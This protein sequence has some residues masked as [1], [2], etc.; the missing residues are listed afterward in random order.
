MKKIFV[1]I[2]F[3]FYPIPNINAAQITEVISSFEKEDPFDLD[4]EIKYHHSSRRGKI[5]RE[6]KGYS[7][8]KERLATVDVSKYSETNHILSIETTFGLYHDLELFFSFP[9]ILE[10]SSKLTP[11]SYVSNPESILEGL[12]DLPFSSPKRAGL[13]FFSTGINWA[14]ITQ[15]KDKTKP[16]W[17]LSIEGR[18]GVGK[19]MKAVKKGD[20]T[21]GGISRG[22][23]EV[24]WATSISKRFKRIEPYTQFFYLLSFPKASSVYSCEYSKSECEFQVYTKPPHQGGMKWGI[25]IYPWENIKAHQ[26]LSIDL[27][28]YTTFYSEGRSYSELFDALG[29][30]E[31]LKTDLKGNKTPFNGLTDTQEYTSFGGNLILNIQPSQYTLFSIGFGI[32]HDQA[33]FITFSDIRRE[34]RKEGGQNPYYRSQIDLPGQRFKVENILLIDFFMVAKGMF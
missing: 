32:G 4:F 31:I 30:S 15:K 6:N 1:F 29:T 18:F 8:R 34:E 21:S 19:P 16:T 12:F 17:V 9:I 26:R 22:L 28:L 13:D 27:R 7:H 10:K 3:F 33:H 25:E 14:P 20:K 2:L 23:V 11:L 5:V 24:K